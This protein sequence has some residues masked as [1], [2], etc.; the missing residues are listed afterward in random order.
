MFE[1]ELVARLYEAAAAQRW[2]VERHAF[3]AALEASVDKAF[4][5]SQ[6]D[7]RAVARYLEGLHLQDI[8][9]ACACAAGHEVAWQHF[10][11]TFR[12]VLYRAAD[13]LDHTG[14]ARE[15]ADA[16]YG[17]LYGLTGDGQVR[18][19]L[20]SYFHGRSSLATWLKAVLSQRWV[21]RIRRQRRH[22]PLPDADLPTASEAHDPERPRQLTLIS[23]V[24]AAVIA[25]LAPR[26]RFRL[27]SYY[28]RQLTLAQIGRL[29]SEH[30]ATVSRQLAR[31]RRDI[32]RLVEEHLSIEY[33]LN[34]AEIDE[35]FAAVTDDPGPL[36]L[37]ELLGS[38]DVPGSSDV[39]TRKNRT[40]TRS[41]EGRQL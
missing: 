15:V 41:N 13:V 14:A 36:D 12:P 37:R 10:I 25:S 27:N 3:E 19:S 11:L 38:T 7:R 31:T 33:R 16:I 23:T 22:E 28:G 20:F 35:C 18:R 9:L 32:R 24:L 39:T 5:T 2:A 8:A 6:R 1:R 26:D 21:D 30:E 34:P 17:D 40:L 4:E 29:L